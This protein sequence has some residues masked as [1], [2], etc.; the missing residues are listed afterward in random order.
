MFNVD[1]KTHKFLVE[2]ISESKHAMTMLMCR[3]QQFIENISNS[4]K[5]EVRFLAGLQITDLRSVT[6]QNQNNIAKHLNTQRE[7]L[8]PAFIKANSIYRV[9]CQDNIWQVHL[10]K[11]LLEVRSE[12]ISIEG[13]N[14][15]EIEELLNFACTS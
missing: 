7:A 15:F 6:G 4:N 1:R 3:F 9:P 8:T 14:A 12:E 10:T 5:F 11:E 2:P 13:F